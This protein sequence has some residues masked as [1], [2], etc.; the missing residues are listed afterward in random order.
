[1]RSFF[2]LVIV[3]ALA[4]AQRVEFARLDR[5]LIEGRL[6]MA[7]G[8]NKERQT[9]L[10]RIFEDAGCRGEAL[11]EQPVR[12][13]QNP[14]LICT[15]PG[16]SDDTILVGAHFDR[17]DSSDGV[18]DNWSGAALLPSL[19]QSLRLRPRYY[20]FVF[21]GFTDEEKGM[22]GS[23]HYV[24]QMNRDQVA[25]MRA[26]INIDTLGLSPTKIWS[27]YANKALREA[28]LQ[29]A[30]LARLPVAGVNIEKV[31]TTD[32]Q[33][34]DARKIP[35]IALH[36]V[37]QET[38][39]VLHSYRDNLK[40]VRWDDYYDSYRL[41]AGY[42]AFLDWKLRPPAVAPLSAKLH[43][44][45]GIDLEG[46]VLWVTSVDSS[47]R[48][49]YLHQID[50]ATGKLIRE[51]EVQE[52]E[53]FH[54]GGIALD[55]DAVWVPVAE[56]RR[57]GKSAVQRRNKQTLELISRFEVDDHIGSVA[58]GP[59]ALYGGNWDS[60]EIYTWDRTGRLLKKS[61]NPAANHYQDMK[62]VDGKLIAS[63]LLNKEEGAVDWLDPASLQVLRRMPFRKTDRGVL[64][65]NEGM[66]FRG[67]K[68]Y[69]LPEDGP[70][71]LFA[72][73]LEK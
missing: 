52:G 5:E 23:E 49:G 45:Q 38:L 34:F 53:R 42:L 17:V 58:A 15:L 39:G 67:G 1:M 37:T 44:V 40:V 6:K 46:D 7:R 73:D 36:S 29:W 26:M 33:S 3:P 4:L 18:V 57:G 69:L 59:D 22:V 9:N 25:Q 31:G 66:T 13:A 47:A 21:V 16:A 71:R 70:S 19:Y 41:I 20:T 64:L 11:V 10:K 62:V 72:F 8:N 63:G 32:S 51:V 50:L 56:Y 28:L 54:P 2:L 12:H 35:S 27:S 61:P 48:K 55:G 24:K 65:T 68:L 43:H 30:A 14:N 60:L